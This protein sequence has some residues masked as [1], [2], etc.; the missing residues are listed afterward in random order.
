MTDGLRCAELSVATASSMRMQ[1]FSGSIPPYTVRVERRDGHVLCVGVLT[2]G[3]LR[4]YIAALS[5]DESVIRLWYGPGDDLE[6]VLGILAGEI[7]TH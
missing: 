5:P 3:A 6:S 4:Q 7:T 1:G 2:T